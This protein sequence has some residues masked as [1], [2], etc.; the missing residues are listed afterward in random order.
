MRGNLKCLWL[1]FLL[2]LIGACL[3]ACHN[4]SRSG[5][6]RFQIT[7]DREI[8]SEAKAGR[9]FVFMSDSPQDAQ[10]LSAGFIP[11][12]TWMAAMEVRDFA[13]GQTLE[14]NPDLKAYPH[15]FSQARRGDYQVLALLD[16]DHS[17]AYSGQNEGDL[18]S[19]LIRLRNLTPASGGSIALRLNHRTE[20]VIDLAETEDVKLFEMQSRSLSAFWKRPVVMR[21]GIVLPPSYRRSPRQTYPALFRIHGFGGDHTAAW[22]EAEGLSQ[23]MGSGKECE[24]IHVFLDASFSTGHTLFVDS[25]CN[26]P[27]GRAL[28]EEFIPYL[29]A[30]FRLIARPEARFLTGHSSGGWSALWLQITHPD[31]FGGVWATA[32]DPVDFRYFLDFDITPGSTEN[33]YRADAGRPRNLAR[34]GGREILSVEEFARWE[35]V[36]GERGG[37]LDSFEWCWSPL[38]ADGRPLRLFDRETGELNLVAQR[39][40]QRYDVRAFLEK[41]WAALGPKLRGKINLFVGGEDTFHLEAAV[42]PLCEFLRRNGRGAV[43]EIVPGRDHD[44]LYQ[45]YRSYPGG[46]AARINEEIQAKLAANVARKGH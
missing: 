30:R 5:P 10:S 14:F 13:P 45:P 25:D 24:L 31:F 34:I 6:L 22:Q 42:A 40:W 35:A 8:V 3:A 41:N 21:A 15:P 36:K 20:R 32:P 28:V 39:A 37:Q 16:T 12:E 17:Y 27:W 1:A 26:G 11:G 46:L 33:A 18:L 7:L 9:L 29:E 4:T 43:C 2:F 19:P 44:N 23:A 38:E